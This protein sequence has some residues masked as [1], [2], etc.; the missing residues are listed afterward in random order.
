MST[1]TVAITV[2]CTLIGVYVI[3]RLYRPTLE[4]NIANSVQARVL[5]S[6]G[7]LND[8]TRAIVQEPLLSGEIYRSVSIPV[9]QG[10]TE[11]LYL[12]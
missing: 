8:A 1:K 9:S 10:V 5:N 3:A 4:A 7:T 11:G 12:R 2:G 6:L